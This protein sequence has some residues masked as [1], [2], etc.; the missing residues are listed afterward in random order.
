MIFVELI[1]VILVKL[2][3]PIETFHSEPANFVAP[4]KFSPTIV[5]GVPPA[6]EPVAGVMLMNFG[7]STYVYLFVPVTEV[8]FG[9]VILMLTSPAIP[10]G[11]LPLIDVALTTVILVNT[12]PFIDTL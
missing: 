2:M 12:V 3:P 4:A 6:V 1:T 11:V 9:V 8:P 10:A 7:S 5:I